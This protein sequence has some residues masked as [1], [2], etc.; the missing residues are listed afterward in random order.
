MGDADTGRFAA[1]LGWTGQRTLTVGAYLL[2]L[3]GFIV[4]AATDRGGRA[5]FFRR[6]ALQTVIVQILLI[7]VDALPII[8]ML[9]IAV[10]VS[11]TA[12]ILSLGQALGSE[13]DLALMLTNIVGV[14][15]SPLL[16]AIVLIGRSGSAMA[17]DMGSMKLRGEM[18]GLQLLGINLN[19]FFVMPRIMGV[20]VA[21]FTLAIYFAAIALF[22][23]VW[24]NGMIAAAPYTHALTRLAEVLRPEQ[25]AVFAVKNLLF[26]V[27]IAGTACFHGMRVDSAA[28]DLPHQTQRAIVTS[29]V[30]VF[31][32]DGLLAVISQ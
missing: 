24:L 25:F 11:I 17:V 6:G 14:E 12:Q 7:G 22:G 20:A 15:L 23:G 29:L 26:G 19:E 28:A 9:A 31:V 3:T 8:S 1:V 5:R 16:T 21:Q 10:G 13:R 30:M 18:E 32:V 4:H 2:D 27:I